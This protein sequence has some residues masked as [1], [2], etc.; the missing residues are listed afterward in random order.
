MYY[1]ESIGDMVDK[2]HIEKNVYSFNEQLMVIHLNGF[3][4][5]PAFNDFKEVH[6]EA[7][8]ELFGR[9]IDKRSLG[10]DLTEEVKDLSFA[11][12]NMSKDHSEIPHFIEKAGDA[13]KNSHSVIIT[14][15]SFPLYNR[16]FDQIILSRE[17]L[18]GKKVFLRDPRNTE[19][20]E[21]LFSDFNLPR[22]TFESVDGMLQ[23][24][25]TGSCD[26][27]FVPNQ[28]FKQ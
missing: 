16:L 14:G 7:L 8:V 15:Y 23:L 12:E 21:V 20:Q 18:Y 5:H 13:I 1:N 24:N 10:F 22:N 27:F 25:S 6:G 4:N 28:I 11:W 9:L 17:N 19:I 2:H 26:S 3:V